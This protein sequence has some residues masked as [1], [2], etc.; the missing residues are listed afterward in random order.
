MI[1]KENKYQQ[2][3]RLCLESS[4]S[5]IIYVRS[6]RKT[7]E[8]S[9]M[10][11][12][13]GV[14]AG[15]FHG[16]L[17]RSEKEDLL[18]AWLGDRTRVMVATSAF[19]MGID[20]ADVGLVIHYELPESVESYFQEA[21]RAGRNGERAEA[22]LLVNPSD[23][24]RLI[25]QF[26][27]VLPDV[28]YLK[29]LYKRLS[30]YF[31][32]AFGTHEE[33]PFPFNFNRFCETY[34]LNT[35]MVYNGLRL[36]DQNS[37]ISLSQQFSQKTTVFFQASKSEIF[38]YLDANPTKARVLQTLLRTYGGVFDFETRVNPGLI[39]K[40]AETTEPEVISV[41]QKAAS[42]GILEFKNERQDMEITFLLPREDDRTINTF[43]HKVADLNQVKVDNVRAV[44]DYVADES[45][46]RSV[47]L[48]GYF[49]EESRRSCGECD[50]CRK[51]QNLSKTEIRSLDQDILSLI[52]KRSATSQY[53]VDYLGR[54]REVVLK[55]L[56]FLLEEGKIAMTNNNEYT[57][58]S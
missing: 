23:E 21:G 49:G 9:R 56:R 40:K 28:S 6:R 31:Q 19:G 4:G 35:A 25:Q 20:K 48:L 27:S 13:S 26:I 38:Q 12:D 50:V 51:K 37:V 46:C 39:A 45:R 8:L 55:E 3:V 29:E 52:R 1:K 30:N 32:I 5:A 41:L 22:V 42:H 15:A 58:L 24:Q 36:L 43:A 11:R 16:G 34:D 10:L 7:V 54:E 57:A 53:L 14:S 44:L 17:T 47:Q 18:K 33:E 2:A